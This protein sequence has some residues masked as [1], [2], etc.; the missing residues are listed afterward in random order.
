[1]GCEQKIKKPLQSPRKRLK[2]AVDNVDEGA[3][4]RNLG[5]SG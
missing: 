2:R 1:M 3:F 5:N 4:R